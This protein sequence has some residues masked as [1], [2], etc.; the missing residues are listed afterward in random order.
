[1]KRGRAVLGVLPAVKTVRFGLRLQDLVDAHQFAFADDSDLAVFL[2][3]QTVQFW[4]LLS[5]QEIKDLRALTRANSRQASRV[6]SAF[7]DQVESAL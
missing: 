3:D 5:S 7:L 2:A 6:S 4:S 1:M